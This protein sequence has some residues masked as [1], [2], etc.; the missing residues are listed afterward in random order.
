MK[1]ILSKSP[2]SKPVNI[3][4]IGNNPIEMGPVLE[5][6][7]QVRT[8]KIIT[9][10]AFDIKSIVERLVNFHPN[11]I[12]IDDNI[13]KEE[14]VQ[15]IN[16]LS[17]SR[18][19]KNIPITVLK[20]NNYKES[21]ASDSIQDYLLKQNLSADVLY[22]TIKNTLRFKRAQRLLFLAYRNRKGLLKKLMEARF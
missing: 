5:K 19:T 1:T 11:F 15:T 4:L 9:E 12:F 8:R 3:L 18:K 7:G 2:G 21:L 13:G 17:S 16:K 10:I 20:N 22:N 14:L 6:L